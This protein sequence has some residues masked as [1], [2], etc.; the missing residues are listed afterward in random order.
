MPKNLT[1]SQQEMA[2]GSKLDSRKTKEFRG[3]ML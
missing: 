3:I 2:A 1:F